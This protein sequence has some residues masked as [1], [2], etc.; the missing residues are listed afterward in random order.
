MSGPISTKVIDYCLNK[1]N[2]DINAL[3]GFFLKNQNKKD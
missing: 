2:K 3:F 1:A